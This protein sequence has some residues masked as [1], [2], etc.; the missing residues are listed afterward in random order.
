MQDKIFANGSVSKNF[1][2]FC[3]SI[4]GQY[5]DGAIDRLIAA[6]IDS[7]ADGTFD[8]F[9][10]NKST[11]PV[12]ES[13]DYTV[14]IRLFRR[15]EDLGRVETNPFESCVI[16]M[17][18]GLLVKR[19][20]VVD[21]LIQGSAEDVASS[22]VYLFG[23]TSETSSFCAIKCVSDHSAALIATSTLEADSYYLSFDSTTHARLEAISTNL[24][25]SRAE[26]WLDGL[27]AMGEII[28]NEDIQTLREQ[29]Q[30]SKFKCYLDSYLERL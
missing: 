5:K 30:S 7:I 13:A 11:I 6:E 4:Y 19:Y 23:R 2:L 21:N 15:D 10:A 26:F 18:G 16:P 14:E 24:Q 25:E 27:V 8:L 28:P 3:R 29:A 12:Y 1:S 9:Y 22:D 17:S 20:E